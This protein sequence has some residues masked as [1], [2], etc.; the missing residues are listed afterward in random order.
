MKLCRFE[1]KSEPGVI[2]S[3]MVYGGKIYETDG[4][5]AIGVHEAV[6]VRPLAP[7]P[8]P[9]SIRIYRT[10]L[11]SSLSNPFFS[12]GNPGCLVG[13]S[14]IINPPEIAT[15]LV[16]RSY[17]GAVTVSGGYQISTEDAE[18]M[19]LGFTLVNIL[20][21]KNL[22]DDERNMGIG[23]GRSHDLGIG[24]GPVLTTPEDL[25]DVMVANEDGVFYRLPATSKVNGEI[26]ESLNLEEMGLSLIEAIRSA[27][28]TCSIRP[29]DLFCI[30]PIFSDVNSVVTAGDEYQFTI[31]RLGTLSTKVSL[32]T[33]VTTPEII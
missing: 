29:G 20:V 27:T 28:E 24:I 14:Q 15:D 10:D 26:R 21:A 30:G 11:G 18:G 3:G 17:L 9:T 16:M 5:E 4:A 12:Y 8:V 1:L 25:D 31:E 33:I 13:P 6:D 7:V 23:F 22:E 2:R 19:I 32:D